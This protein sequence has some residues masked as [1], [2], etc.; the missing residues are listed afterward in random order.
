MPIQLRCPIPLGRPGAIDGAPELR[1]M[2][3]GLSVARNGPR[4]LAGNWRCCGDR[5]MA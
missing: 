5:D 2:G 3:N 4:V 1:P